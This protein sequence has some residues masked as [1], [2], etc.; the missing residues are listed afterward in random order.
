VQYPQ[1]TAKKIDE[2]QCCS[3]RHWTVDVGEKIVRSCPLFNDKW[4]V[5]VKVPENF[6][7]KWADVIFE[8]DSRRDEITPYM[9][10]KNN[11]LLSAWEAAGFP[12]DWTRPEPIP[13]SAPDPAPDPAP[14]PKPEYD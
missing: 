12:T 7:D 2:Y 14:E 8:K 11:E 1:I 9:T 4:E 5:E 6:L 13:E 3:Y 10:I